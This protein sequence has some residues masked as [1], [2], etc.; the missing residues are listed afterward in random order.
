[1]NDGYVWFQEA[2]DETAKKR[3]LERFGGSTAVVSAVSVNSNVWESSL[4][5][6]EI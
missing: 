1:M 6:M 5:E 3:R 2:I 4:Y